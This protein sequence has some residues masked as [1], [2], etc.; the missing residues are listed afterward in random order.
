[1]RLCDSLTTSGS[2]RATFLAV[3]CIRY[4]YGWVCAGEFHIAVTVV[5]MVGRRWSEWCVGCGGG[6]G[7]WWHLRVE[8]CVGV[9][10]F[11]HIFFFLGKRDG[12]TKG[13][14]CCCCLLTDATVA[15]AVT[16]AAD[17]DAATVVVR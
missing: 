9:C 1:M 14:F 7:C 8:E 11:R 2:A 10:L 13:F 4:F 6:G 3:R 15:T 12:K 17:A 5:L 16:A